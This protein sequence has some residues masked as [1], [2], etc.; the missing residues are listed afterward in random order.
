MRD[1]VVANSSKA[2]SPRYAPKPRPERA[3]PISRGTDLGNDTHTTKLAPTGQKHFIDFGCYRRGESHSPCFTGHLKRALAPPK[4]ISFRVTLKSVSK[5]SIDWN[6][7]PKGVIL[8]DFIRT[9]AIL[10]FV[11]MENLF[12]F[13]WRH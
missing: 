13:L 10:C 4:L 8:S 9:F 11:S 2:L 1:C 12:V 7:P 5:C 6:M 3:T